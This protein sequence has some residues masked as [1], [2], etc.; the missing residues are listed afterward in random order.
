MS[1]DTWLEYQA[2]A[3]E[4]GERVA[5]RSRVPL[6]HHIHEGLAILA[7]I[8]ATE[9][10]MR[11][12]CLHPL[13]QD[14]ASHARNLPRAAELTDDPYVL[15]LALEYRKVANAALSTRELASA[16]DIRLSKQPEVNAMLVAD[17][18]QNRKDFERHHLGTHP[19]SDVLDRYFRLWLERLGVNDDRYAE[20]VALV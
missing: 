15:A 11:A 1:Y 9:R 16:A 14:D 20:L 18:V 10:A 8:G 2:I 12:F 5:E 3:R 7:H 4:Y 13:L 6:I 19:R 17:K